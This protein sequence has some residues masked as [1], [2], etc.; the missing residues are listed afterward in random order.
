MIKSHSVN[1]STTCVIINIVLTCQKGRNKY[2]HLHMGNF[3]PTSI[4]VNKK[5]YES[6]K[7]VDLYHSFTNA[8]RLPRASKIL[9][10]YE[11]Y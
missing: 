6:I 11:P 1:Y 9:V 8:G 5:I 3:I 7:V 4:R 10:V 2:L